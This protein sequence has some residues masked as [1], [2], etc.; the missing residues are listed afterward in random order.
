MVYLYNGILLLLLLLSH[1]SHVRFCVTPQ[2]A[3][4]QA[5]RPWDY[6]GKNTGVG[7]WNT[8]MPYK[9]EM[10]FVATG[11]L[12]LDIITLS[13]VSQTKTSI[14]S[15][16]LHVESKNELIYKTKRSSQTPKTNLRSPQVKG[17]YGKGEIRMLGLIYTHQYI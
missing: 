15:Y 12:D 7:Q 13:E 9:N 11:M 17:R 6:P 14:I 10:L 5:P 1:F 4:H 8:A 16:C 3:A 2:T